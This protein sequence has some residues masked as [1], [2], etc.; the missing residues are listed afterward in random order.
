MKIKFTSCSFNSAKKRKRKKRRI[1][2]NSF[3]GSIRLLGSLR[4]FL[5]NVDSD[6]SFSPKKVTS[7]Q[8]D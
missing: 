7:F 5:K 1:K 2:R 3:N 8:E 4:F 6:S